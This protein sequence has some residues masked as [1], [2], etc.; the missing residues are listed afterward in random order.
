[1][2]DFG[3]LPWRL[4]RLAA[5]VRTPRASWPVGLGFSFLLSFGLLFLFVLVL[6]FV[7]LLGFFSLS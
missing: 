1:M 6:L 5:H 2:S 7:G 4:P 3:Y